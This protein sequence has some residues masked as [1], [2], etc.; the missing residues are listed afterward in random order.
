MPTTN[1]TM[2]KIISKSSMCS[3]VSRKDASMLDV[4]DG[5]C[6][7]INPM[8]STGRNI[9]I[10]KMLFFPFIPTSILLILIST[11]LHS[12]LIERRLLIQIHESIHSLKGINEM[13]HSLQLELEIV[14][15]FLG[16]DS[17]E[18]VAR[19]LSYFSNTDK[20]L[21]D[22]SQ[23]PKATMTL[24]PHFHSKGHFRSYLIRERQSIVARNMTIQNAIYFYETLNYVFIDLFTESIQNPGNSLIWEDLLALKFILR[25]KENTVIMLAYGQEYITSGHLPLDDH[26]SFIENNALSKD[27][28]ESCFRFKEG[29]EPLY[30]ELLVL[31]SFNQSYLLTM[32]SWI[33]EERQ[34]LN[35]LE[36]AIS[37]FFDAT[38]LL[39]IFKEIEKSVVLAVES[40]VED[41]FI[42][43]SNQVSCTANVIQFY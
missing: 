38:T 22:I 19:L 17:D 10:F 43:S 20:A 6:G 8:T 2:N 42:V 9:H 16:N 5:L 36:T 14:T 7:S 18:N 25:A 24:G 3:D 26:V 34:G 21:D 23:W 32:I 11:G 12:T 35:S 13:V 30:H 1:G 33:I 37:W 27:N 40:D 4:R 29:T 28:L 15:L 31:N 41:A 39:T